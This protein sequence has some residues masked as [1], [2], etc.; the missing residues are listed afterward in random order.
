MSRT[1]CAQGLGAGQFLF[2]FFGVGQA[3]GDLLA[4]LGQDFENG[5]VGELDKGSTQ[6]REKLMTWAM[7]CGQSRPNFSAVLLAVSARSLANAGEQNQVIHK[8]LVKAGAEA[9]SS[10]PGNLMAAEEDRVE[11]DGFGKGHAQQGQD[12]DLA[13]SAGIAPDRLGGFHADQSDPDSRPQAGQ[14]DLEAAPSSPP[15]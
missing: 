8:W 12:N 3:V 11:H 10:A 4:A 13:E 15:T 9:V 1:S 6:T 5:L 14:A 2:D 7:K